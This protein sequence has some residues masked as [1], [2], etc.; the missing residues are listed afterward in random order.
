MWII[1]SPGE[2]APKKRHTSLDSAKRELTRLQERAPGKVFILYRC[3][4][5]AG[6]KP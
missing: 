4:A 2:F 1:W 3:E 6:L 5:I